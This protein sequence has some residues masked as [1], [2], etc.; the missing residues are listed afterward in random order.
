MTGLALN[1]ELDGDT[2]HEECA[3]FGIFGHPE[4]AALTVLGLH[5]LQDRKSVV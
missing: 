4:A 5:A 1:T 3:V 2:L